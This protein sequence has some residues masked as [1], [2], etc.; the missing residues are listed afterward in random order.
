MQ[1]CIVQKRIVWC[2][3][4]IMYGAKRIVWCKNAIMYGAK[5]H[6]MV[7]KCNNVS[8]DIISNIC[9]Q[10]LL[11]KHLLLIFVKQKKS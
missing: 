5:T 2:K 3:N 11:S 9:L 10:I 7:Q 1:L 4:A 6:C 8:Y